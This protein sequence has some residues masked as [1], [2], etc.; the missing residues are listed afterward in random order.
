MWLGAREVALRSR[1]S[2]EAVLSLSSEFAVE[3]AI[4]PGSP[5]VKKTKSIRTTSIHSNEL[6][7]LSQPSRH[8]VLIEHSIL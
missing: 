6:L 5:V 3:V 4:L 7:A 1:R 2:T 8:A